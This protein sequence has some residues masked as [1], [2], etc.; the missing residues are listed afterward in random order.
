MSKGGLSP[1][2]HE[3]ALGIV[4]RLTKHPASVDF[5]APVDYVALG[6]LDYPNVITRPMDLGTVSLK[7]EARVYNSLHSLMNDLNLIWDN[8]KTYNEASSIIVKRAE[9][10]EKLTRKWYAKLG[11]EEVT[12]EEKVDLAEKIRRVDSKMMD[13]VVE[14]VRAGRPKAVRDFGDGR[15]LVSLEGIDRDLYRNL[16]EILRTPSENHPNPRPRHES[17]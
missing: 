3:N 13:R 4:S 9:K 17:T 15:E 2:D 7:L 11:G 10:L 6:L 12:F 5:L 14:F 1:T 16:C 8:C